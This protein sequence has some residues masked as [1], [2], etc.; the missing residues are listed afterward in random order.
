MDSNAPPN[1]GYYFGTL[2]VPLI[3]AEPPLISG[4][5]ATNLLGNRATL[6]WADDRPCT[7]Q[8]TYHK[9]NGDNLVRLFPDLA[10]NHVCVLDLLEPLTAYNVSLVVTDAFN[11]VTT[12]ALSFTG[13]ERVRGE[14]RAHLVGAGGGHHGGPQFC[15]RHFT[16]DIRD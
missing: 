4:F 9:A 14:R 3:P 12:Q 11:L 7:A 1:V 5:V 2:A 8:L 13:G 16:V 10:T 6:I 15:A